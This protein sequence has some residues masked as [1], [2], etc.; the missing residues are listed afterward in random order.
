MAEFC[1][2]LPEDCFEMQSLYLAENGLLRS[3]KHLHSEPFS[4]TSAA[5]GLPSGAEQLN[6]KPFSQALCS[7]DSRLTQAPTMCRTPL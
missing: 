4:L 3:S 6:L 5:P 7:R 2:L 1:L